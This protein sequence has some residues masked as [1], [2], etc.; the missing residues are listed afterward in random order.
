MFC[1]DA[2]GGLPTTLGLSG[3]LGSG[4]HS[5]CTDWGS[6]DNPLKQSFLE[7]EVIGSAE[8]LGKQHVLLNCKG[9]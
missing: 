8:V 3:L 5:G 4:E 7:T 9:L 2:A 1:C 6:I